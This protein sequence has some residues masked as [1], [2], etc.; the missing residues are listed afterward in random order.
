MRRLSCE[1]SLGHRGKQRKAKPS[2]EDRTPS[3]EREY[4]NVHTQCKDECVPVPDKLTNM[5]DPKPTFHSFLC[6]STPPLDGIVVPQ[7][8]YTDR[9]TF[10]APNFPVEFPGTLY[11]TDALN[12]RHRNTPDYD[13]RPTTTTADRARLTL[14]ILVSCY[15]IY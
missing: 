14:R 12:E 9:T 6:L 4:K 13:Q 7:Q 10:Q 3:R 15:S 5:P 8:V 2:P 11:L 1:R